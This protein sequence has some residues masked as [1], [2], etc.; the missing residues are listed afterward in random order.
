MKTIIQPRKIRLDASTACQL[1]CPA[2]PNASGEVAEGIG[3]GF[4]R[5]KDFKELVDKNPRVN[6]I[7]LSNWGEIFLNKELIRIIKYAYKRN[8]S[9]YA[10]NSVNLN[11]VSLEV[12]EALV[13][14]RVRRMTCS[15]DGASQETYVKYR[16]NGN[17]EQV[18]ENI[19]TINKFKTQYKSRYP[20][21]T[22]QFI[23]FGHNE[24]EIAKARAMADELN[25]LFYVKLSWDDFYTDAFSPV[26]NTELVRKESGL[27]AASRD[28]FLERYGQD[29]SLKCGCLELWTQPQ[30]NY[31]GKAL[32][33]SVNFWGDYG[34]VFKDG[35]QE[36]LNNEKMSYAREVLMGRREIRSD[37]PCAQC[38][39]YKT[40]QERN[41]WVTDRDIEEALK[42]FRFLP[43]LKVW[44]LEH[45]LMRPLVKPLVEL[46]R[47][48]A[49]LKLALLSR[50][51]RIRLTVKKRMRPKTK[52]D[53]ALAGQVYPLKI[54]LPPD[55]KGGWKFYPIFTG[56]TNGL[57]ELSCHV[58]VLTQGQSPHKPHAH[59]DEEILMVLSGEVDI[60]LP[61]APNGKER[62]PLR[63]GDA[64]YYP[65]GFA[66]TIQT[67]SLYPANY[68]M[69][70]WA[71]RSQ[72]SGSALGF[73]QRK[74][75]DT[76]KVL[77]GRDDFRAQL[78][79][80][81]KTAYL[82]KLQCHT[83]VVEPGAGYA[84]H[85]D[86]YD[87]AIIVFEGEVE[88]LGECVGPYSVIFYPAGEPHGLRNPGR[89]IAKYVVF[90]FHG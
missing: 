51:E 26:K 33:C 49:K 74:L 56:T 15:I 65:A 43:M 20:I 59:Q 42:Q 61:N 36:I 9:L 87:V 76:A 71:A 73:L 32:G 86:P 64:V 85:S 58:S 30:I 57:S 80:E 90:E 84:P 29:Y 8:I 24:H 63:P 38:K 70:K 46:K 6:A 79:F 28:E 44:M 12:L 27:G 78:L 45:A 1:K 3:T 17:F 75:F 60:V 21:L 50:K 54:P 53:S 88:T 34:N 69:F 37:I 83:S 89:Q 72:R 2:C 11:D 48:L 31:D 25:M 16:V 66:H 39:R 13:K 62:M 23:A 19:K 82:H 67:T 40:I 5:F 4:L 52:D 55:E 35:L 7:E 68:L 22:W 81:G 77:E 14:Y 41:D 18:I 10:D 47:R